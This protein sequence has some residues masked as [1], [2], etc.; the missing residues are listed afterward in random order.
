MR[1][2]GEGSAVDGL[3]I[4]DELP[5][6]FTAPPTPFNKPL[7]PHRTF[8]LLSV[9]LDEVKVVKTAFGTT[10][11]DVVL[12]AFWRVRQY[13]LDHGHPADQ[14]LVGGMP[15]SIRTEEEQGTWGNRLAELYVYLPVDVA[16]PVER[17]HAANVPPMRP[18]P[19]WQPPSAVASKTSSRSCPCPHCGRCSVSSSGAPGL[20]GTSPISSSRTCPVPGSPSM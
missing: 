14:P 2:R 7:T 1:V 17:L 10:V 8:V 6:L 15:V 3:L 4:S 18:K 13:L 5:K 20:D 12:N 11:N 19:T 9:G 16:D